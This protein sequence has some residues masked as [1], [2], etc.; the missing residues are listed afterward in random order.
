MCAYVALCICVYMCMGTC[1]CVYIY[2]CI[3]VCICMMRTY[4]FMHVI[5][6][7]M[8]YLGG[9]ILGVTILGDTVLG[10]HGGMRRERFSWWCSNDFQVI[11]SLGKLMWGV[12]GWW[13]GVSLSLL[14]CV[15]VG[16]LF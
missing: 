3:C 6:Y 1:V 5:I 9:T 16:A 10:V 14:V 4:I 15:Y 11:V 7:I 12:C 13:S 8:L 2:A